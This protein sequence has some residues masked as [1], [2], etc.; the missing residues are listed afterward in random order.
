MKK[1][2][3]VCLSLMAA[4]LFMEMVCRAGEQNIATVH[5]AAGAGNL[6]F[7]YAPYSK[8]RTTAGVELS[9][10]VQRKP[11]DD[12]LSKLDD[13]D[14]ET[15]VCIASAEANTEGV[16]GKALVM[17]IVVNRVYSPEFP[18]TVQE[19]VFQH[20]TGRYEFSPVGD[21]SYYDAEITQ[22]SYDALDLVLSGWDGSCGATY[23][24]TPESSQWHENNLEFLFQYGNH[25]FYTGRGGG[26]S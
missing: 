6:Q 5:R 15:L 17:R 16:Y 9:D 11:A 1:T 22:E 7:T 21:G 14:K 8:D 4:T 10:L 12:M 24:C 25:R 18:N 13:S 26:A 3:G 23:F 19:V 20:T 2:F